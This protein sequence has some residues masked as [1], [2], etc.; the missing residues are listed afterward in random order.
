MPG[1]TTLGLCS[2]HMKG[3]GRSLPLLGEIVK[4]FVWRVRVQGLGGGG[5]GGGGWRGELHLRMSG[6]DRRGWST[7][8]NP[9]PPPSHSIALLPP[10]NPSFVFVHV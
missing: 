4:G 5:G 10:P 7:V 9:P 8:R 3:G 1:K 6:Y 2:A